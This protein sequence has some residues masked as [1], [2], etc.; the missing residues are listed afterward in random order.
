MLF[1]E[2]IGYQDLKNTLLQSAQR[3]QIAHAQLFAG[4]EGTPA[5]LLALAYATYINCAERS[6]TDACGKCSSC[7]K[8]AKLIHPDLHLVFP[9]AATAKITKDVS[10]EKFLGSFR[11]FVHEQPYGNMQDW[12][13]FFGA[14]NK[15]LNIGV[16]EG[17]NIIKSLALKAYEATYKVLVIW[18]PELMNVQSANAILKILEEPPEQ[19]LFLLVTYS[20]EK[21]LPTILSRT[22]IV[23]I[24]PFDNAEIE[25][26]LQERHHIAV[27]VSQQLSALSEGNMQTALRLKDEA[28]SDHFVAFR[29]W[30]RLCYAKKLI[31]LAEQADEFQKRGREVQKSFFMYSLHV[32]RQA[33]VWRIAGDVML[34]LPETEADF[35]RKFSPYITEE[36][37]TEIARLLSDACYH[38]ERNAN[39]KIVFL[40][41][42]IQISACLDLAK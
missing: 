18:L 11:Q 12:A 41:T 23:G 42:S 33:I 19:T 10:S 16:E 27:N 4:G 15:Q 7:T 3:G 38:I 32:I 5:L 2:I 37:V 30:I 17:R 9:V 1:S 35:I 39:P 25:Q 34:R 14:E 28:T 8:Y 31:T 22:Q 21:L 29:D 36:N 6:A 26:Y 40:D 13:T 24:R 20:R